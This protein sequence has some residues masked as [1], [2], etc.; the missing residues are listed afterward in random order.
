MKKYP[1]RRNN[2]QQMQLYLEDDDPC[3]YAQPS[4]LLSL[5]NDKNFFFKK[6]EDLFS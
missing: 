2:K 1:E 4:S 3:Q 6:L 5:N